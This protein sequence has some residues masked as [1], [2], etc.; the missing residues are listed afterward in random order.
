MCVE[1]PFVL[2]SGLVSALRPEMSLRLM[3]EPLVGDSVPPTESPP[4]LRRVGIPDAYFVPE[5]R[6]E[7]GE[8]RGLLGLRLD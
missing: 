1:P 3:E 4:L 2:E 6:N 7:R 8:S 5:K